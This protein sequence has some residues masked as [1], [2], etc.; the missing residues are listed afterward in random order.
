MT[1]TLLIVDDNLEVCKSLIHNFDRFNY[2]SYYAL[3]KPDALQ[4]FLQHQVDAVLLDLRLG[5]DDGLD[6][7]QHFFSLNP[8]VPIIILT[9]FA[10][11]QT[12]VDSIKLGAYDYVQK[13]INFQKLQTLLDNAIKLSQTRRENDAIKSKLIDATS[14]II[15]QNHRVIELCVKAKKLA[16]S[17]MPIL[18][19]GESGTGKELIADFIHNNSSRSSGEIVK[20]NCSAFPES[21]IDNELFGHE[22]GAF[23]GADA[24]FQGVFERADGSSL[25]LD[26]IAEMPLTTQ[27]KILRAIQNQ[28]I[29]RIGGKQTIKI[30]TRFIGATNKDLQERI[31]SNAFREDLYYRLNTATLSVPPLRERKEDILVLTEHFLQEFAKAHGTTLKVLSEEVVDVFHHYDWPGN[32]REL[33]NTINYA[34]TISMKDFIDLSDLPAIFLNSNAQ[35]NETKVMDVVEKNLIISTLKKTNYNKK[36]SA[37][38][39]HISR[40]TLYNKLEKYGITEG[41]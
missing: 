38:I 34:A 31:R 9:G 32:V 3:N 25:F 8:K 17:D 36:K 23:T 19:L 18:I 15:T 40:R 37:E 30:T 33:K 26:E 2:T 35:T 20:I 14:K 5:Q 4:R 6:L 41:K 21:L 29:R 11:I 28:E 22:K 12:A 7:L 13:P 1:K 27:A 39:L 24:E 16:N 10:S